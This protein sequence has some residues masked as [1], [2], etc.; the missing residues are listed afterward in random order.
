MLRGFL[1]EQW[2]QLASSHFSPAE[3]TGTTTH[4]N[5]GA[6]RV[7]RILKHSMTHSQATFGGDEMKRSMDQTKKM[8]SVDYQ[9]SIWKLRN[10][11]QRR[12]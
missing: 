10:L 5:N 7:Y 2:H 12:I 6:N 11:I 1:S 4:R 9:L 8:K 3:G